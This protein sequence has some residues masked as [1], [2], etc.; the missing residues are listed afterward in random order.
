MLYI[1]AAGRKIDTDS[2]QPFGKQVEEIYRNP[3]GI[4]RKLTAEDIKRQ[5]VE[6]LT[7]KVI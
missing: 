3:F 2:V 1:I 6:R 5:V 4:K 7:G